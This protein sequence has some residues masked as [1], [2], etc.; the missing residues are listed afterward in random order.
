MPRLLA[1]VAL[2]L[3]LGVAGCTG[4]DCSDCPSDTN[5]HNF[6]V[7]LKNLDIG[8][9]INFFDDQSGEGFPCCEVSPGGIRYVDYRD[10]KTRAKHFFTVGR[11]GTNLLSINCYVT[12]RTG[13]ADRGDPEVVWKTLP[14]TPDDH[15]HGTLDCVNW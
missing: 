4:D 8:A 1:P 2:A 15:D 9:S 11:N 13:N 6:T 14:A 7:K 3:V 5:L 10:E 12:D